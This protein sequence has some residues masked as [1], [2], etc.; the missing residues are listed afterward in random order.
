MRMPRSL[1][2][3]L[4]YVTCTCHYISPHFRYEDDTI[5]QEIVTKCVPSCCDFIWAKLKPVAPVGSSL[6]SVQRNCKL[7]M[8]YIISPIEE[9][10][11]GLSSKIKSCLVQNAFLSFF[12]SILI[13]FY[14]I[15]DK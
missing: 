4:L 7:Q 11:K 8:S 6:K 9:R 5:I 1:T 2:L 15:Y 14:K 10:I 13:L 3:F 12:I